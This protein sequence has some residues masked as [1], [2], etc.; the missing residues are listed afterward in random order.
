MN[1]NLPLAADLLRGADQI[2]A[3]VGF[4]KRKVYHLADRGH[5]PLFRMGAIICARKS[6]LNTWIA[7]QERKNF[8]A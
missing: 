4:E 1:D 3:Y 8:A 5:L 7:D 6:T 2:A